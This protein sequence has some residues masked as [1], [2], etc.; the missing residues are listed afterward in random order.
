MHC[1]LILLLAAS[2]QSFGNIATTSPSN[3]DE[4]LNSL[5]SLGYRKVVTTTF[6]SPDVLATV[7]T[8]GASSPCTRT[9]RSSDDPP[10]PKVSLKPEIDHLRNSVISSA[11]SCPI[12]QAR[13]EAG[14][15]PNKKPHTGRISKQKHSQHVESNHSLRH[16]YPHLS[17]SSST[18][19]ANSL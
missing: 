11:P 9:V 12:S 19:T 3:F 6:S 1:L 2:L 7:D 15:T 8:S 14:L 5:G 17:S 16:R 18:S 4:L 13:W 10:S